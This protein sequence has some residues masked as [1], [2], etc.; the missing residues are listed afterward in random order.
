[1][2]FKKRG[3]AGY[4]GPRTAYRIRPILL[5]R[6][7]YCFKGQLQR[8]ESTPERGKTH[9]Q[10]QLFAQFLKRRIRPLRDDQ[11]LQAIRMRQPLQTREPA[12]RETY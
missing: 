11:L 4:V 8:S 6:A 9:L 7:E 1:M 12:R 5:G 3:D 10:A 2:C